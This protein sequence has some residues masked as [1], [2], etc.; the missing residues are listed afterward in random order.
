MLRNY[1]LITGANGEVGHGLV[2]RLSGNEKIVSL[3][4]S[5]LDPLLSKNID[6]LIK[7][8]ITDKKLIAEIF[9]KYKIE[10][11]YHLA[12]VLSTG[13][14]KNPELAHEVNVGGTYNLL[15]VANKVAK[16]Q[17]RAV[18]FIFPSTIAVYGLPNLKLK[19]QNSKVKE[20][21]FLNPIT[22]YGINKLYCE[23]LGIYFST[24]YSQLT[25]NNHFLDFRCVRFPGLISADTIPSGGT[26]DYAPEMLHF[27]AQGKSYQC[28]V[29][30][31]SKIHFMAMPD[32]IEALLMLT[33][34]PKNK[35]SRLVYNISG[36]STSTVDIENM[37]KKHF[38]NANISY[39]V[40]PARQKIV[41]S[42]SENVDDSSAQ[43]DWGW[44][45]KY[46]FE[47]AF[48][49]YLIPTIIYKYKKL[50]KQCTQ[51]R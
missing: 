25:T 20:G 40:D 42:W 16:E 11:I 36:F 13:G 39:K 38:P 24:H 9:N 19:V 51:Y 2:K 28:F 5:N 45:A 4:H 7:A 26:S 18:K 43:K 23:N 27:A 37:V 48:E 35:L 49:E 31:D 8:D 32:A 3:Y 14:E 34:V 46:N 47:K 41:D 21:E 10:T 17:K 30:P 22:M 29:R 12:A 15:S 50:R 44:K 33:K 1:V 6:V